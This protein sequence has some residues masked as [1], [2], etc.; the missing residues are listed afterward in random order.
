[1]SDFM[2]IQPSDC[3]VHVWGLDGV[4]DLMEI[5]SASGLRSVTILSAALMGDKSLNQNCVGLLAKALHP[6]TI[7]SFGC[8][9]H[10]R[11]GTVQ[12]PLS[13]EE[14]ARGLIEAGCDGMKMLEGKPTERKALEEPL[15]SPDYD[16]YYAYLETQDIPVLYH[17]ADPETFWDPD[18]PKEIREGP[19]FYGGG[20][21]PSKEQI[22]REMEHVLEKF[23][24]LRV[25]FA[26]FYF[27]SADPDRAAAFLEKYPNT[28]LDLT[29]GGEMYWN[30]SKDPERWRQFF[31]KYQDRILFGTDNMAGSGAYEMTKDDAVAKIRGMR[32]FLETNRT[33]QW[34]GGQQHGLGLE[35]NVLSKIYC[36]NFS[37]FAG[38]AP[39]AVDVARTIDQCQRAIEL[40]RTSPEQDEIIPE[41]E[42]IE[43]KL[44]GLQRAKAT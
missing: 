10:P 32:T 1:M 42:V 2:E 14:Q 35:P 4:P 29:P 20:G 21:Y 25:V 40:A 31:I 41:L 17:V 15:D 13:Y 30:F 23:P 26:H 5:V 9:W 18:A 8:L 43:G 33:F 11:T 37:R 19:W 27:L 36:D 39:K 44:R 22:Y 12:D 3:H 7:Y 6:G 28:S 24:K 38:R 16:A 34:L